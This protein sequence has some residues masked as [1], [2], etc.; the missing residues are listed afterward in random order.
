[1]VVI[2]A[3]AARE[4]RAEDEA[5]SISNFWKRGIFSRVYSISA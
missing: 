1:M 4:L 3:K 5:V 2:A